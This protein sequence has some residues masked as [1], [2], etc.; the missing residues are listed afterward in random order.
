MLAGNI[1]ESVARKT[2]KLRY[3]RKAAFHCIVWW[4]RAEIIVSS[5][6]MVKCL[7]QSH[8]NYVIIIIE[9]PPKMM[10]ANSIMRAVL[11]W[12]GQA[13]PQAMSRARG[14]ALDNNAI[15]RLAK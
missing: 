3:K 1:S 7:F 5:E 12:Y 6:S 4:R 2:L 11:R 15:I 9:S 8:E 13:Y 14:I 10:V